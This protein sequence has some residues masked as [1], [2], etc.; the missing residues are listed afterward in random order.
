MRLQT[1]SQLIAFAKQLE[2]ESA[3]FYKN[4]LDRFHEEKAFFDT[5]IKENMNFVSRI[6]T[7][8]YEVISDAIEGCFAFDLDTNLYEI[9]QVLTS[10]SMVPD[11]LRQAISIEER[12]IAF[13]DNSIDQ[14]QGLL[15]DI[16][17]AFKSV[18]K[19]RTDRKLKLEELLDE[20]ESQKS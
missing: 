2:T 16:P 20:V 15:A 3:D 14:S 12:I 19:K 6:E 17:R 18:V 10:D 9:G 5:L 11:V 8:Y 1:A 7:V 4:L 13:Y